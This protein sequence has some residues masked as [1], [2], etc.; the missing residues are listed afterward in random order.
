[1]FSDLREYIKQAEELGEYRLIEGADWDLEIG[2]ITELVAKPDTPLLMFDKIKDYKPGYRVATNP[3]GSYR[4]VSRLLGLPRNEKGVGL[5]RAWREKTRGGFKPVPPVDI[6]TGPVKEN[7]HIGN[8][9]DLFE[10]PM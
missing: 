10:F 7:I 8:D 5:V 3:L 6:K 9:V 2:T 4:Q 1:M